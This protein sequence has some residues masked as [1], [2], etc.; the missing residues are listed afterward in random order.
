M[1]DNNINND[2]EVSWEE[3]WVSETI[4]MMEVI[5]K[6]QQYNKSM[7]V[8]YLIKLLQECKEGSEL[9]IIDINDYE[10]EVVG[11]DVDGYVIIEGQ[12][13]QYNKDDESVI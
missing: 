12:E 10:F 6:E 5:E 13:Q 2:V 8:E 1:K 9:T 7:K 3:S 4:E 11:V